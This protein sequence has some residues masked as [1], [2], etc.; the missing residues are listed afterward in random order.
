MRGLRKAA[1]VSQ[2]DFE[3]AQAAATHAVATYV[4]LGVDETHPA[5]GEILRGIVTGA[6][7][8][9][10]AEAEARRSGGAS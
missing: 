1:R 4:K 10:L 5:A 9:A 7:L 3:I 8:L 2:T 6:I